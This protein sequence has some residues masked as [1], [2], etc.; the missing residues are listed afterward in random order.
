MELDFKLII[1]MLDRDHTYILIYIFIVII[2]QIFQ[3]LITLYF[4]KKQ[5]K[6]NAES[7]KL[8]YDQIN[9]HYSPITTNINKI[10]RHSRDLLNYFCT[11]P[12]NRLDPLKVQTERLIIK[13]CNDELDELILNKTGT[14]KAIE[15]FDITHMYKQKTQNLTHIL[16]NIISNIDNK[17]IDKLKIELN[18]FKEDYNEL[19]KI[20]EEYGNKL[21]LYYQMHIP[22]I[23]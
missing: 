3:F 8:L 11:E 23:Y 5:F 9:F 2:S 16:D 19:M 4:I 20:Y 6:W 17:N 7:G 15:V 14:L 1:D 22:L 12:N 13:K 18:F 21:K 10:R